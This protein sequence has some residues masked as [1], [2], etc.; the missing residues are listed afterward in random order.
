MRNNVCEKTARPSAARMTLIVCVCVCVLLEDGEGSTRWQKEYYASRFGAACDATLITKCV[1]LGVLHHG[2][3]TEATR[4][5]VCATRI[6]GACSG[7]RATTR[8]A[9]Q[10][11]NGRIPIITRR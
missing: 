10:I 1:R 2:C 3:L 5:S 11:G 7:C 9:V 4:H 8:V 6:Y